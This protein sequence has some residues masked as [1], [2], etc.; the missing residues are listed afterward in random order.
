MADSI[1]ELSDKLDLIL[2]QQQVI[3]KQLQISLVDSELPKIS[4]TKELNKKQE[5]QKLQDK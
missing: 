3:L 1:K 4:Q 5:E 2:K